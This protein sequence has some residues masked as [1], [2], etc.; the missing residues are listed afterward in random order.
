[1]TAGPNVLV[2]T[3]N[4][5]GMLWMTLAGAV[6]ATMYALIRNLGQDIHVFELIF[7]RNLFGLIVLVPFIWRLRRSLSRPK[8]PGLIFWRGSFQTV[9]SCLWYFGVTVIPL[10]SAA[11][12]MLIEPIV[13]SVLAIII[14]KEPSRLGRWVAV[15]VGGLGALI[16]IRPGYVDVSMGAAAVLMAAVLWSC[17]QLMGKVHSREE[18]VAVV[19]AYSS[20]LTVPLSLIPALFFWVTPTLEQFAGL[21]LLG[22]VA[23]FGY[24]CITSA[25]KVGDVTVV[26]PLTFM[27]LIFASIVGYV[28][29]SEIPDLWVWVGALVVVGSVTY[30]ARLEVKSP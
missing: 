4:L 22:A 6:F 27:R 17:F 18:P 3:D 23:T 26:S 5:R 29:F 13:A 21:I 15:A 30:L 1:M 24:Y 19:I 16:I 11:A 2:K 20:A 10:A 14:F 7:F 9:S 8:R 12:I 25:Y 28:A